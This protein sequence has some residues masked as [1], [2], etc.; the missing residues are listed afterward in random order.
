MP[1]ELLFQR[2]APGHELKAEA[3]V[4]HREA[5]GGESDALAIDAGDVLAVG[6]GVM[7]KAGFAG[8]LGARGVDLSP[9]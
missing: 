6:G 5:P 7:R 4:D 8:E 3:V 9:P 2:R 1:P